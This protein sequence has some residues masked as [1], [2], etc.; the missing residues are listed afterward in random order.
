MTD[1][2]VPR[3]LMSFDGALMRIAN[4]DGTITVLDTRTHKGYRMRNGRI[5]ALEAAC[6]HTNTLPYATRDGKT[7]TLCLDCGEV[8]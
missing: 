2:T 6:P 3:L 5:L 4:D 8:L 7:L 1:D